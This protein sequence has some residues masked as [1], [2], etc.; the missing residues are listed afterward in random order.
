MSSGEERQPSLATGF[1]LWC[2][3]HHVRP[4]DPGV[5]DVY[6]AVEADSLL[7]G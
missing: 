2:E 3:R 1:E 7:A 5:F 4:D 6:L